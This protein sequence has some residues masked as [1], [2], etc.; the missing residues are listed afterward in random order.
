M[1]ERVMRISVKDHIREALL[2]AAL[3]GSIGAAFAQTPATNAA[4]VQSAQSP[5]VPGHDG[6]EEPSAR[7]APQPPADT[8]IFVNGTLT[9]PN[10]PVDT[11]TTPAKFSPGNDRLD[12][13]PIMARGPALTDAQR[14]LILDRVMAAGGGATVK[15][16]AFPSA[17]LPATVDMHVWPA[18]I[19]GQVPGIRDTKYVKLP[20]KILVVRPESW[21]VV[22]EI[23]K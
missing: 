11:S 20:D 18:D 13:L 3:F 19:V 8:G 5:K 6:I 1:K 23:G 4:D 12:H 17:M 10:A 22:E 2:T 7:Q 9:V 21:I 15:V 16:D 14:K